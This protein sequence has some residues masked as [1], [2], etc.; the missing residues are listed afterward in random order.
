VLVD[1]DI[2]FGDVATALDLEPEYSLPDTVH[3]PA[4]RDSMVLK[5]FLTQHDTGLYV[6]C[7]ARTPADSD[8]I[9]GHDVSQL[10]TMLASEFRYVVVDTA[11][12]LS[13]H[14]LAAMDRTTDLI[15]LTSMDVPGV[16]GLRKE[17][18]ALNQ[19]GLVPNSR[20]VVLNFADSRAGLSVGDVEATIGTG[21]DVRLPRSK[22]IPTSINQ[23]LPLLQSGVRDPMTK[24]LSGL[25]S[26]LTSGPPPKLKPERGSRKATKTAGPKPR[27][28]AAGHWYRDRWAGAS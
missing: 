1:L 19:L 25:V 3:G 15:L 18:D 22:A 4:S 13:D 28:A 6:I 7:G 14:T 17:L 16:R 5:T 12:G 10:L 20:Y 21:V 2:Q 27:R 24:Q 8:A 26:R 11:P 23:G 9:S